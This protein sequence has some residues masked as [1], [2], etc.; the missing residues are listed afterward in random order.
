MGGGGEFNEQF[1]VMIKNKFASLKILEDNEVTK[2]SYDIIG[3]DIK[4]KNKAVSII[5][6]QSIIN[7]GSMRK[8][9]KW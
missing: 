8:V 1:Q 9:E 7:R 3:E 2:K 6:N 5:V 4:I